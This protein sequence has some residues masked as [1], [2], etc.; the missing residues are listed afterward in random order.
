[1]V[2]NLYDTSQRAKQGVKFLDPLSSVQDEFGSRWRS[3]DPPPRSLMVANG[4]GGE[5]IRL[6]WRWRWLLGETENLASLLP[7]L[8]VKLLSHAMSD[9]VRIWKNGGTKVEA[10][11][12]S[13]TDLKNEVGWR[14]K[15]C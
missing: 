5:R 9:I 1:M 8:I 13:K 14:G 3:V 15:R 12:L 10:E 7:L 11:W 2:I 6:Q 4:S